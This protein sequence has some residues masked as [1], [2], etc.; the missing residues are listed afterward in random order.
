MKKIM[1]IPTYLQGK[2][3]VHPTV[4][5]TVEANEGITLTLGDP[6]ND[7]YIER[8]LDGFDVNI[9][10]DGEV[11]IF[12]KVNDNR[13]FSVRDEYGTLTAGNEHLEG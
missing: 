12:V 1:H 5:V 2:G 10:V 9:S 4:P 8:R 13:T 3:H 6:D 11:K 7:V